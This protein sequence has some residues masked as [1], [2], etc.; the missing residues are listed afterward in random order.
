[1]TVG[2]LREEI[3]DLNDDVEV[4]HVLW[5]HTDPRLPEPCYEPLHNMTVQE[6]YYAP[7]AETYLDHLSNGV[8][9]NKDKKKVLVIE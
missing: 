6:L 5:A 3:K 2:D 7:V 1:M 4:V 8:M 9:V